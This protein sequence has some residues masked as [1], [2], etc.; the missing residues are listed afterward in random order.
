VA[1]GQRLNCF[2][3]I[4]RQNQLH[5]A[6]TEGSITAAFIVNQLETLSW[7]L[8]KPTVIVLDN[9]RIHTGCKVRQRLDDWQRRGLYIFYLPPYSPH[10]NLAERLWKELKARRE[11]N[12]HFC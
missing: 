9:A 3:L 4:S 1:K 2:G 8:T 7:Q 10:L 11:F 6:T 5:Y 12:V